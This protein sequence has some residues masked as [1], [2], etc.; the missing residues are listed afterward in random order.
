ML[1]ADLAT[2]DGSRLR[3]I[4]AELVADW[5]PN[6][7]ALVRLGEPDSVRNT[8]MRTAEPV[9]HWETGPVTLMGDAIHTMVP[10]GNSAAVALKDASVLCRHLTGRTGSLLEA[11]HAYETEMLEYGFRAVAESLRAAG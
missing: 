1:T 7:G 2:A 9:S 11:V 8:T 6:F 3:R 10:V 4:A 5:H